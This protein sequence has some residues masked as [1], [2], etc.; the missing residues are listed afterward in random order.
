MMSFSYGYMISSLQNASIT[1]GALECNSGSKYQIA[2]QAG[3]IVFLALKWLILNFQ[4]AI[5]VLEVHLMERLAPIRLVVVNASLMLRGL[6]VI[7]VLKVTFRTLNV[8]K[9]SR[10]VPLI[11]SNAATES[12]FLQVGFV[13][14]PM[15]V[16]TIL[17]S[18]GIIAHKE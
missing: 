15:I 12:V 7:N 10:N 4:N 13:M 3:K 5:A 16:E 18:I 8:T 17:T 14:E 2:S 1:I 9:L 11:S 6:S